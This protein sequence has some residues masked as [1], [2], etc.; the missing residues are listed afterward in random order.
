MSWSYSFLAFTMFFAGVFFMGYLGANIPVFIIAVTL[1][2]FIGWDSLRHETLKNTS[3]F[4]LIGLFFFGLGVLYFNYSYESFFNKTREYEN[5]F[6]TDLKGTVTRDISSTLD[7]QSFTLKTKDGFKV[8]VSY[9][10]DVKLLPGDIVE[11]PEI[12]IN[13]TNPKNMLISKNVSLISE[14]THFYSSYY[15]NKLK[16][17]GTDKSYLISRKFYEIRKNS[18]FRL[19]RYLNYDEAAFSYSVISSDKAY[20]SNE[21]Y[22]ML[23][24]SGLLHLCTVS[25]FHFTFLCMFLIFLT[26]CFIKSYRPR[27][28]IVI[29]VASVFVLYTGFS[30]SVLRAY[31]MFLLVKMCDLFYIEHISSKLTLLFTAVLFVAINPFVIYDYSF[32]LTFSAMAGLVFVSPVLEAK[33]KENGFA[34]RTYIT[35]AL[36]VNIIMLP[37]C[38]SLF[39]RIS[40]WGFVTNL[41]AEAAISA[42]MLIVI[43]ISLASGIFN[44]LGIILSPILKLIIRYV[45]LVMSVSKLKINTKLSLFLPLECAV[46]FVIMAYFLIK[47]VLISKKRRKSIISFV[48]CVAVLFSL[49][50]VDFSDNNAY[51]AYVGDSNGIDVVHKN[52]HYVFCNIKDLKKSAR[53]FPF[54]Q[55]EKIRTLFIMDSVENS[56]EIIK[57]FCDTYNVEK[58]YVNEEMYSFLLNE[59]KE[60]T[61]EKIKC[62]N[63][64]KDSFINI[65]NDGKID[66]TIHG[67]RFVVLN[68]INHIKR[69]V[70]KEK[71]CTIFLCDY[72][73]EKNKKIINSIKFDKSVRAIIRSSGYENLV[74]TSDYSLIT[75]SKS[76]EIK[77]D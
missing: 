15:G 70:Q 36:G 41:F 69:K 62:E 60:F 32:I 76:G 66:F 16:V 45:F 25:G 44:W 51:I 26:A 5:S 65:N 54:S 9:Y 40:L 46:I 64:Y 77:V 34:G 42:L 21:L 22:D 18:F 49:Y 33:L 3:L 57:K 14:R 23:V 28:C 6:K 53:V 35:S 47:A 71:D 59:N 31:F 30:P 63:L 75:V 24:K 58:I 73:K 27:V 29:A 55:N 61:K 11:I 39:G 12:Y 8:N 68:D 4:I 17:T 19:L 50:Y 48:I 38:Y 2:L 1:F 67:K 74:C 37:V 43:L 7:S 56:Y 13:K 20:I 52:T 10:G 72:E